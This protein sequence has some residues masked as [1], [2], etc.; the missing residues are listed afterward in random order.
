MDSDGLN[1]GIDPQTVPKD[2]TIIPVPLM[3]AHWQGLDNLLFFSEC[4][5]YVSICCPFLSSGPKSC[6]TCE[7]L[8]LSTCSQPFPHPTLNPCHVTACDLLLNYILATKAYALQKH[9]P[10][11]SPPLCARR[12]W[13]EGILTP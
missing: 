10:R 6:V 12:M 8:F 5:P 11:Q 3:L 9:R 4:F 1:R 2:N 13:E 7:R